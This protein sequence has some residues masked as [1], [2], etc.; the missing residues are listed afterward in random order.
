[1]RGEVLNGDRVLKSPERSAR[2]PSPLDANVGLSG[3]VYEADAT[4]RVG[5]AGGN[6]P[7]AQWNGSTF[8]LDCCGKDFKGGILPL[9]PIGARESE[10]T[11]LSGSG[12]KAKR[13]DR[14]C[15]G[16]PA[17]QTGRAIEGSQ[18]RALRQAPKSHESWLNS[19]FKMNTMVRRRRASRRRQ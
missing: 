14:R 3:F 15:A 16:Q 2:L 5:V 17:A 10:Q 7:P 6:V 9:R 1:V 18:T 19:E 4:L 8:D 11:R 12:L 13:E